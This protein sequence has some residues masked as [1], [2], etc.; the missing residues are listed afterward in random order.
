VTRKM[1]GSFRICGKA[2]RIR[3]LHDAGLA[4]PARLFPFQHTSPEAMA[5]AKTR[6]GLGLRLHWIKEWNVNTG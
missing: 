4:L 3:H 6:L 5:D 1:A 2:I